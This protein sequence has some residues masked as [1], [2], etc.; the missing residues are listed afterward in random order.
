MP[1]Q[2]LDMVL[3]VIF[4]DFIYKFRRMNLAMWFQV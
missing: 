2:I 4:L 3:V 1:S